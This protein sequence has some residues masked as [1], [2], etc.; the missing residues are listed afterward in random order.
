MNDCFAIW[1][2]LTAQALDAQAAQVKA[3]EQARA[4]TEKAAR[5]NMELWKS[6]MNLWGLR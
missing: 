4:A 6:W 5:A 3:A 1:L 2:D